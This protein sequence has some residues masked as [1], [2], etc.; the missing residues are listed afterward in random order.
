MSLRPVRMARSTF[1]R[2]VAALERGLGDGRSWAAI[3]PTG[4]IVC[5]QTRQREPGHHELD[6]PGLLFVASHPGCVVAHA[7]SRPPAVLS[8]ADRLGAL[9]WGRPAYDVSLLV[10]VPKVVEA[11][12]YRWE[13]GKGAFRLVPLILT[14]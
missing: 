14:D 12:A 10:V 2:L 9:A 5:L 13:A 6:P 4:R 1:R 11:A 8:A 3:L 7:H